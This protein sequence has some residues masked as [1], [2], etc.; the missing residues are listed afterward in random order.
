MGLMV[1]ALPFG[2]PVSGILALVFSAPRTVSSSA[3]A[4][5]GCCPPSAEGGG[6]PPSAPCAGDDHHLCSSPSSSRPGPQSPK[7]FFPAK[8]LVS[9]ELSRHLRSVSSSAQAVRGSCPQA[10]EGGSVPPSAP[11]AGDG[12]YLFSSCQSFR[13]GDEAKVVPFSELLFL[14]VAS[15]TL[16]LM[17]WQKIVPTVARANILYLDRNASIVYVQ[18]QTSQ[19]GNSHHCRQ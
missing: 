7:S 19:S 8:A 14:S 4:V 12:H 13:Q 10:A 6:V 18:I 5:R 1:G 15:A 11:C 9:F 3:P 2:T 16:L 17:R